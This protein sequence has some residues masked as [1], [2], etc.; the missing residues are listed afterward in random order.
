MF[1]DYKADACCAV[2]D[3]HGNQQEFT[4]ER[5]QVGGQP[6]HA[7]LHVSQDQNARVRGQ[8]ESL[9]KMWL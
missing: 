1:G 3:I 7:V 6:G 4:K 5:S 2:A 9:R 8:L